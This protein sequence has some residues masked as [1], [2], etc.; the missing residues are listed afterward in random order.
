M[1]HDG[2]NRHF[3]ILDTWTGEIDIHSETPDG[4]V[5]PPP[6]LT[7]DPMPAI[8]PMIVKDA[9]PGLDRLTDAILTG[10][11]KKINTQAK[12]ADDADVSHN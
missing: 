10:K 5:L 4:K 1:T 6:I 2:P 7:D 3:A 12:R 11:V 8:R 9:E